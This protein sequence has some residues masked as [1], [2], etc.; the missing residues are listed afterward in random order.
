MLTKK[1]EDISNNRFSKINK[2]VH[3]IEFQEITLWRKA[4][5]GENRVPISQFISTQ[6]PNGQFNSITQETAKEN[7]ASG[8]PGA[9]ENQLPA[10]APEEAF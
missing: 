3:I 5:L 10:E 9:E 4:E 7:N 2:I 6:L 8:D 1:T